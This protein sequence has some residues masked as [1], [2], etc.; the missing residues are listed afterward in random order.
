[1][2]WIDRQLAPAEILSHSGEV[3]GFRSPN[4]GLGPNRQRF[5][6]RIGVFEKVDGEYV[7][8]IVT[9]N[10]KC[11]AIIKDNPYR[12]CAAEPDYLIVHSGAEVFY[13]DLGY[14]WEKKTDGNNIPYILVHLDDPVFPKTIVAMLVPG[15]KNTYNLFWDRVTISDEDIEKQRVTEELIPYVAV[16]RPLVNQPTQYLIDIYPELKEMCDPD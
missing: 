3:K 9:L 12:T 6:R 7:G 14:A 16:L 11:K 2:S 4:A 1:M 13:P 10:F 8:H 15:P 5:L